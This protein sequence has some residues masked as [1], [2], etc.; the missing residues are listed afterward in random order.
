MFCVSQEYIKNH[1]TFIH[2]ETITFFFKCKQNKTFVAGY[3]Y[4]RDEGKYNF[5][6][7]MK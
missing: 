7:F 4:N 2:T 6:C 3:F 1:I 5:I